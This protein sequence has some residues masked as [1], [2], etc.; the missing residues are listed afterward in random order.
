MC[1]LTSL[2]QSDISTTVSSGLSTPL[3]PRLPV[4]LILSTV[5]GRQQR[6]ALAGGA[7]TIA[8]W[9]EGHALGANRDLVKLYDPHPCYTQ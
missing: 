3:V 9:R 4:A 1:W 2:E 5:G 7:A 8:Q 6:A